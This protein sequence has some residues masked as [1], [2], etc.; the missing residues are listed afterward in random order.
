MLKHYIVNVI[1]L[2]FSIFQLFSMLITGPGATNKIASYMIHY[3][4]TNEIFWNTAKS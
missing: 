2:Q 3:K 4:N 1:A